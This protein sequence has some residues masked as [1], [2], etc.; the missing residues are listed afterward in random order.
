MCCQNSLTNSV[1]LVYISVRNDIHQSDDWYG[2][3]AVLL[4]AGEFLKP[5]NHKDFEM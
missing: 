4:N 5:I 3:A 2:V 1:R